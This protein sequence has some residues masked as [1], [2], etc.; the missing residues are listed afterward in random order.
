MTSSTQP[1]IQVYKQSY[2]GQFTAQTI[3]TWQANSS[4]GNTPTAIKTLFPWQLILFQSPP[5]LF[6]YVSDFQLETSRL[7]KY[8]ATI[9]LDFKEKLLISP[10]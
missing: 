8:S 6:Q 2:L 10:Y 4:T 7:G 3:E 5:T 1:N 9:H